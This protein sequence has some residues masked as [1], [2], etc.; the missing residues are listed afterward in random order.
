MFYQNNHKIVM[1][2]LK[3]YGFTATVYIVTNNIGETNIWDKSI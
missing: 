3:Q 1:P 2:I